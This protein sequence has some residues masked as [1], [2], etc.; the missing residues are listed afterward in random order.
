MNR[1]N[2]NIKVT[3]AGRPKDIKEL[4]AYLTNTRS[5]FRFTSSDVQ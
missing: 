1:P 2:S 3:S 4:I 5:F